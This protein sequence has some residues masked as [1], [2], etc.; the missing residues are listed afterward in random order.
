M[1][2]LRSLA[3]VFLFIFTP[4]ISFANEEAALKVA[5]HIFKAEGVEMIRGKDVRIFNTFY[6][7]GVGRR[8]VWIVPDFTGVKLLGQRDFG[9]EDPFHLRL[10]YGVI[11]TG[12]SVSGQPAG[13]TEW[14]FDFGKSSV[15]SWKQ[16]LKYAADSQRIRISF[17]RPCTSGYYAGRSYYH[18]SIDV[19]PKSG[20]TIRPL[21]F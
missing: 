6:C 18:D 5:K 17:V 8:H 11:V 20:K 14:Q 2:I 15:A 4:N 21:G 12:I 13:M 10:K 7:R 16:F 9:P 1:P 19:Y 3:I